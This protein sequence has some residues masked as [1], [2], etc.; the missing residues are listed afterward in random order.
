[1]RTVAF[2]TDSPG[3]LSFLRRMKTRKVSNRDNEQITSRNVLDH[4]KAFSIYFCDRYGNRF[5]KTTYDHKQL[6][7]ALSQLNPLAA[8]AYS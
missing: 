2:H 7:H 5:E 6:C 4:G 1:M 3:F 8:A